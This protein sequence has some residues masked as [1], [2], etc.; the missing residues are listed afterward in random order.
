MSFEMKKR[1]LSIFLLSLMLIVNVA[2]TIAMHFCGGMFREMSLQGN[3][4]EKSCCGKQ[5]NLP[6]SDQAGFH[7]NCC[8]T[9]QVQIVAGD[10]QQS[11]SVDAPQALPTFDHLWIVLHNS[12]VNIAPVESFPY[13]YLFPPGGFRLQD[14]DLLSL[15]CTYLI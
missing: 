6:E 9:Q 8:T 4:G 1:F 11:Q 15:I 14:A 10:Y 7:S 13:K 12:T 2:P 5:M 3:V